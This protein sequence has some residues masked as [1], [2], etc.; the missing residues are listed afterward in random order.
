M[1]D[2]VRSSCCDYGGCW[3]VKRLPS[4]AVVLRS[5][6]TGEHVVGLSTEWEAFIA[7]VKAGQFDNL[8]RPT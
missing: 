7:G 2:W 5:T 3:E 4:G 6:T 1:T 8:P